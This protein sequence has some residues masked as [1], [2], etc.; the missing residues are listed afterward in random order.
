[1]VHVVH[2]GSMYVRM[3]YGWCMMCHGVCGVWHV[4][5]DVCGVWYWVLC[6][7]RVVVC[8]VLGGMCDVYV[9]CVVEIMWGLCVVPGLFVCVAL[10]TS[11]AVM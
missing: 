10:H 8:V 9:V 7:Q 4:R 5:C 2:I 6:V 3:W 11:W 1:M